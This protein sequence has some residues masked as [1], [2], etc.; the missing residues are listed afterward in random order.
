MM[1]RDEVRREYRESE[2]DPEIKAARRRAHQEMLTGAMIAAVKNATVVIVNP[3]RLA[4]ALRY[5]EDEDEAP[6]V[7]SQGMGEI[8]RQMIDAAR[9]YGIPVVRDV[10]VARALKD[11]EVGEEIPEA[12]YEAV[13]EILREVWESEAL[14]ADQR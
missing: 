11:L 5:V 12:L 7:V 1:T 13:A 4:I 9:A 10:P 6:L 8:A 3:T 2:G 14:E